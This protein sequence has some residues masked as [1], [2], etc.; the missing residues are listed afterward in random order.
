MKLQM[1][2]SRRR[3]KEAVSAASHPAGEI[4]VDESETE[5]VN[6]ELT[7]ETPA[8][9]AE[10]STGNSPF[11]SGDPSVHAEV[12][13][14][15][16]KENDAPELNGDDHEVNH[17]SEYADNGVQAIE[18]YD[19]GESYLDGVG[20]AS[21]DDRRSFTQD[22]SQ[23]QDYCNERLYE[24]MTNQE[25]ALKCVRE[26][27][28]SLAQSC[29]VA[30]TECQSC[31]PIVSGCLGL[32]DSSS[33]TEM[34]NNE[35]RV[36]E[37]HGSLDAP[38]IP[39]GIWVVDTINQAL[40]KWSDSEHL[41]AMGSLFKLLNLSA[42]LTYLGDTSGDRVVALL[43]RT[44]SVITRGPEAWREILRCITTE[45][46]S[47][48]KSMPVVPNASFV[49]RCEANL[50]DVPDMDQLADGPFKAYWTYTE[51]WMRMHFS[52]S[53]GAPRDFTDQ[54]REWFNSLDTSAQEL[55]TRL[56]RTL[57]CRA[58]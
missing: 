44:S 6:G 53:V 51:R 47:E 14:A 22:F 27:V 13:A 9:S 21:I 7:K 54:A 58:P 33:V 37:D 50:D 40:D 29:L 57:C 10:L 56:S 8:R 32:G 31:Q 23:M 36:V 15:D 2:K 18:A 3:M 4:V 55:F 48:P 16:S 42:L 43:T 25:V 30:S 46:I 24:L 11:S 39:T 20:V 28:P 45:S 19:G 34:E 5:L 41:G 52:P 17:D 35:F 49:S 1:C 38:T 12:I 26:I